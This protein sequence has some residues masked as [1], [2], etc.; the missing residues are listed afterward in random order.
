MNDF[1]QMP[2]VNELKEELTAAK[3]DIL[4]AIE[5]QPELAEQSKFVMEVL[6][7]LNQKVASAKDLNTLSKNEQISVIA[8]LNLFYS[9]L[10]DIFGDDLEDFE[11]ED[12][13]DLFDFEEEETS[14]EE[15]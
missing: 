1:I 9:L 10:E 3:T 8:H 2:D 11:D 6:D 15:K 12:D 13:E 4:A 7:I 14:D 5:E